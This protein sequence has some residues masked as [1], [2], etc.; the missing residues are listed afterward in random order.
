MEN[1]ADLNAPKAPNAPP[2]KPPWFAALLSLLL[3]GLGQVYSGRILRGL[4]FW[5]ASGVI[6][7][8]GLVIGAWLE[9][10]S[11]LLL[12]LLASIGVSIIAAIDAWQLARRVEIPRA[13]SRLDRWYT[14][15]AVVVVWVFVGAP[16]YQGWVKSHIA[17]TYRIPS[18]AM[19]PTMEVGDFLLA[20]PKHDAAHRGELV[21]YG[22][23]NGTFVKRVVA[24]AGDT[25]EMRGGQLFVS[26]ATVSEPYRLP[27]KEDVVADEFIWQRGFLLGGRDTTKY[28]PSLMTWGPLIVPS[29]K[30][31]VL[32]DNRGNSLDD[33]YLGFTNADSVRL[34]PRLVYFSWDPY[35]R[36]V[37]W[38]RIGLRLG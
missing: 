33:R 18:G 23:S 35:T 15:A 29:G 2:Q 25:I 28:R 38:S 20:A 9:S 1:A 5:V 10:A 13:S 32:G 21:V 36:S 17:Q 30:L 3:A 7:L 22:A 31:F 14:Y 27:E 8:S 26:G 37:R 24:L 34:S 16:I 6:G 19:L 4:A 11:L 12:A